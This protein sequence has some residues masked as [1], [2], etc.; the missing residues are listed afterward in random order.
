MNNLVDRDFRVLI[1]EGMSSINN[2][3]GIGLQA[4]NLYKHLKKYC[5]CDLSDYRKLKAIPK[6]ARKFSLDT[7]INFKAF[8]QEYDVIHYQNNYVPYVRGKS[9][10][11]VTVHDLG[12]FFFP[13]T[14]PFVYVKYNQH[15]IKKAAERANGIITPSKTIKDEF[16]KMF[17][18]IDSSKIFTCSD[19]IRDIFWNEIMNGEQT[20]EKFNIQPY[21]YFFFLGSL[22]R[23]K[24]LKFL[25]ESFT[26]A[27]TKKIIDEKTLLVLGGQQWWRAGDFKHLLR[28]EYGIRTL[29]YLKDEDIVWLYKNSKAFIFPSV[30]EGFGMPIIEAMSQK[31]PIIISNIPT[32]LELNEKHNRQMLSFKLGDE[33]SLIERLVWLDKNHDSFRSK[34]NY[35]DISVYNYDNVAKQHLDIYK[36]V[37]KRD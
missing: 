2:P 23:R 13:D 8:F 27:K 1:D 22:S 37:M 11:I 26:K 18:E 24:N 34:L 30:Y 33:D 12:V 28:E 5:I 20:G 36:M 35:G 17:Q 29:G 10:K 19:G 15:S 3:T 7:L 9:K 6:G 31:A 25:L 16:L 14:V 4:V 21:S 32:S